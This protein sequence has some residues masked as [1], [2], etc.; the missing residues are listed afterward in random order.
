LTDDKYVSCVVFQI[1]ELIFPSFKFYFLPVIHSTTYTPQ[2]R[3]LAFLQLAAAEDEENQKRGQIGIAYYMGKFNY[4]LNHSLNQQVAKMSAWLPLKLHALHICLNYESE[5]KA[6]KPLAMLLLGGPLRLR[7]RIHEGLTQ[8]QVNESLS[9]F[10]IPIDSLAMSQDG[11]VKLTAHT[12]W[13][14]RR[15]ALEDHHLSV[16]LTR[17]SH[18]PWM[19]NGG[20]MIIDMPGIWD[21]IL[22]R[23]RIY[24][25]HPGNIRMKQIMESQLKAYGTSSTVQEKNSIIETV[26]QMV[27]QQH[28][29][30]NSSAAAVAAGGGDRESYSTSSYFC[31]ARFVEMAPQGWWIRVEE[32]DVHRRLGKSMRSLYTKSKQQQQQQQQQQEQKI[33]EQQVDSLSPAATATTTTEIVDDVETTRVD[34]RKTTRTGSSPISLSSSSSSFRTSTK[35]GQ[36]L[37]QEQSQGQQHHRDKRARTIVPSREEGPTT[38]PESYVNL[39][40]PENS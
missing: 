37:Q 38:V 40:G 28:H 5:L 9:T 30:G 23:G 12:K 20:G 17:N 14:Q 6:W 25:D 29:Y 11:T 3:A 1:N 2:L 26:M 18:H 27:Q 24:H 35:P 7:V 31:T 10:G 33:K 13:I 15:K 39:S 22:R 36:S 34:G 21:V 16:S 4:D 19:V 32:N 8:T